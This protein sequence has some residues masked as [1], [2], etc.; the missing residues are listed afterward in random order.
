[1]KRL[2]GFSLLFLAL[3]LFQGSLRAFSEVSVISRSEAPQASPQ[4]ENSPAGNNDQG[5]IDRLVEN[6]EKA[7]DHYKALN[8]INPMS[9]V[10]FGNQA[11]DNLP[12]KLKWL[13]PVLENKTVIERA[14]KIVSVVYDP[15]VQKSGRAIADNPNLKWLYVGLGVV[16]VSYFLLKR[17]VLAATDRMMV[18]ALLRL[19]MFVVFLLSLFTV[20]YGILGQPLIGMLMALKTILV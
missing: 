7:S 17:R 14:K 13:K 19:T 3:F 8:Q 10:P 16:F 20:S 12:E 6:K 9:E 18:R 15:E 4:L 2:Q 11:S 1:M 5:M